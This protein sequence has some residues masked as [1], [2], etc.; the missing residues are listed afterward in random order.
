MASGS[1]I[2]AAVDLMSFLISEPDNAVAERYQTGPVQPNY[3]KTGVVQVAKSVSTLYAE[4]A[5]VKFM[6]KLILTGPVSEPT[7]VFSM[8]H[9]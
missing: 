4:P 7:P 1:N 5:I 8:E 2:S 6:R 9:A 3:R